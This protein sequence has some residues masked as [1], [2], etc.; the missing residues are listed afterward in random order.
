MTPDVEELAFEVALQELE[1]TVTRLEAG[2]LTLEETLA[3]F[4][5]GRALADHCQ[6]Q[7]EQA[8]LRVEVLTADGEI[9]EWAEGE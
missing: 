1:E 5:R 8:H 6:A 9:A 4:E 2:G 3:L 7:L